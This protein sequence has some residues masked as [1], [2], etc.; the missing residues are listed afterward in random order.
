[1]IERKAWR[2]KGGK[3]GQE[4]GDREMNASTGR[5]MISFHVF[6][7]PVHIFLSFGYILIL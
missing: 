3:T 7:F 1:M 6:F 5:S 4:E 2:D